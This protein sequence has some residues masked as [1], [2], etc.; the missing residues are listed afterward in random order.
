LLTIAEWRRLKPLGLD[1]ALDWIADGYRPVRN[2]KSR[3]VALVGRAAS[4]TR[5]DGSVV[6]RVRLVRPLQRQILDA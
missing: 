2:A 3:R 5:E 6:A 1:A 4:E